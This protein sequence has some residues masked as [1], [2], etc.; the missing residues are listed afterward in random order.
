MVQTFQ[1]AEQAD[2]AEQGHQ[3]PARLSA[4]AAQVT[5]VGGRVKRFLL[6]PFRADTWR[7]MLHAL[8]APLGLLWMFASI[9]AM[10]AGHKHNAGLP[11][12][13]AVLGLGALAVWFGPW[14]ELARVRWFLG[15]RVAPAQG[16]TGIGRRIGFFF[17][18]MAVSGLAFVLVLGTAIIGGRNLSYPIWGWRPYPDPDWGGPTPVGAVAV[19]F[20]AGVAAALLFPWLVVALTKVHTRLVHRMLGER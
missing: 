12:L 7:R 10:G 16:G 8:V 11:A 14:F 4:E 5:G 2:R 17:T 1:R 19:H 15:H 20:A 9:S 13:L 18:N 3:A 6:T